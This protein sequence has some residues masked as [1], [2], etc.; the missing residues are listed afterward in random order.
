MKINKK[1]ISIILAVIL[2]FA[3]LFSTVYAYDLSNYWDFSDMLSNDYGSGDVAWMFFEAKTY[4][5]DYTKTFYVFRNTEEDDTILRDAGVL[6]GIGIN[7]NVEI[8]KETRRVV[9]ADGVNGIYDTFNDLPSLEVV[10]MSSS[11]TAMTNAFNNCPKLRKI[12]Y[13][14][15]KDF[16]KN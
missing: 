7:D 12:V 1:I 2:C 8:P 13:K 16:D 10:E 14:G 3:A 6:P 9:I 4:Y 15:S 11:I 5:D